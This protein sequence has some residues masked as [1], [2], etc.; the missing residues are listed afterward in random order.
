MANI[1]G[2]PANMDG[3]ETAVGYADA[4]HCSRAEVARRIRDLAGRLSH[5]VAREGR[6]IGLPVVNTFYTHTLTHRIACVCWRVRHTN[7]NQD[8]NGALGFCNRDG[9]GRWCGVAPDHRGRARAFSAS[10]HGDGRIRAHVDCTGGG[11]RAV[12]E[13]Y[14]GKSARA[15]L[16]PEAERP[17]S[18]PSN[19]EQYTASASKRT[20]VSAFASDSQSNDPITCD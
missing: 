9:R 4:E 2:A 12:C 14:A 1:Y 10:P 15:V 3:E 5:A 8:V 11:A 13:G 18:N 7:I 16:P 6:V 20:G 19:C 17:V